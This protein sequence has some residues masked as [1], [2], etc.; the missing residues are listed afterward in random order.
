M[1]FDLNLSHSFTDFS[2]LESIGHKGYCI[3]QE[4]KNSMKEYTKDS[5]KAIVPIVPPSEKD[6]SF[7]SRI[8]VEYSPKL[9]A[10]CMSSLMRFDIVCI[11]GVD[12]FNISSVMKLSPDL[13]VLKAEEIKY[14]K[15][16]FINTLKQKEIHVELVI[17][18][19]LYTGKERINWMN[20]LRR[21]LRFGCA[22]LVVISSGAAVAT[23]LKSSAD[24]GKL[25]GI[26]NL[27][28]DKIKKILQNSEITLQS[29]ALK[30]FASH[31][32][33]ASNVEEGRL[34]H[35]FIVSKIA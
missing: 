32:S 34:K 28:S 9:D 26:F 5:L 24:M 4:T 19:T 11:T 31:D 14:L 2:E 33:C 30:R 8:N 16:S 20:S 7:Y 13:V 22:S 6:I 35:D 3:V 17:R 10:S 1:S 29:A 27:G 18:D 15:R 12:N 21:L 25:L 23:E